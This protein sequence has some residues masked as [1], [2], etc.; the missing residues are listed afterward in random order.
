M[1]LPAS[2]TAFESDAFAGADTLQR[3]FFTGNAPSVSANALADS[4]ATVY[5]L[6]G[7]NGWSAS[8]GGRPALL[9]NPAPVPGAGFGFQ[10]GVFGFTLSGTALIPVHVQAAADLT[11]TVWYTITNTAID[12]A[13]TLHVRDPESPAHAGRYYRVVWP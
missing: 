2:I 7:K 11:S 4:A 8:L 13:G 3:L 5:Y 12:A 1:I 10:N 6:P 9:W